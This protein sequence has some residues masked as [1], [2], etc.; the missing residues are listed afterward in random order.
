MSLAML[1]R[2]KALED[3]VNELSKTSAGPVLGVEVRLKELENKY[4]MLNARLSKNKN[5]AETDG[6]RASGST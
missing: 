3:R 5:N 6:N 4:R 2:I 1:K